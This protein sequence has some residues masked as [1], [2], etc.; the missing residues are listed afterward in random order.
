MMA[1]YFDSVKRY[2]KIIQKT[3]IN[4]DLFFISHETTASP[5]Y[6]FFPAFFA[7]SIKKAGNF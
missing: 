7:K 6:S 4:N 1:V 5:I 3:P 2:K